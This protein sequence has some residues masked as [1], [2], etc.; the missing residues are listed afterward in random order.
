MESSCLN[1]SV[2]AALTAAEMALTECE[3]AT[4]PFEAE[5]RAW[6][7]DQCAAG[8]EAGAA[9]AWTTAMRALEGHSAAMRPLIVLLL[10][11]AGCGDGYTPFRR[12]DRGIDRVEASPHD[13]D[14]PCFTNWSGR[15]RVEQGGLCTTESG[16]P[17]ECI[18]GHCEPLYPCT[19]DSSCPRSINGCAYCWGGYCNPVVEHRCVV[20]R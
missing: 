15:G 4:D 10:A 17:G 3:L 2:E 11:L 16:L 7:A 9:H 19:S 8:V 12:Y 1:V 13:E 6:I 20:P 14:A 5:A 18:S